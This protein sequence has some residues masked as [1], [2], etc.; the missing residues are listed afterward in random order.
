MSAHVYTDAEVERLIG[1][2]YDAGHRAGLKVATEAM[3]K[4]MVV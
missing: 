4:A 2:A 3:E 1:N